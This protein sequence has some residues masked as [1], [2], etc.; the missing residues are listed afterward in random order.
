M[1]TTKCDRQIDHSK[2]SKNV[3]DLALASWFVFLENNEIESAT[4]NSAELIIMTNYKPEPYEGLTEIKLK[5]WTMGEETFVYRVDF[6][7]SWDTFE[8]WQKVLSVYNDNNAS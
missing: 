1:I 8:K 3:R 5:S 6:D 7:K 2:C 4:D